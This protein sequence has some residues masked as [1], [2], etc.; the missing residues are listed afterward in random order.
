MSFKISERKKDTWRA[1]LD[2]FKTHIWEWLVF[3]PH[4][5]LVRIESHGYTQMQGGQGKCKLCGPGRHGMVNIQKIMYIPK[6][7]NNLLFCI[8]LE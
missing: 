7:E 8:I 3:V 2:V 4:L 6:L 5:F 1:I